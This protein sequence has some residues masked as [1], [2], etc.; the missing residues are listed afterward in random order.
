MTYTEETG[1]HVTPGRVRCGAELVE[2]DGFDLEYECP[3]ELLGGRVVLRRLR[4][5][6][7][8]DDEPYMNDIPGQPGRFA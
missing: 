8:E 3:L 4:V 1:R 7:W 2:A 5:M 6:H